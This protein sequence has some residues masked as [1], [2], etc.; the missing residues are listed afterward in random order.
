MTSYLDIARYFVQLAGEGED[1]D[2][3]TPLRLHKLLYYAQGWALAALGKPLFDGRFEAWV[4]G[5][6][7]RDLYAR[8]AGSGEPVRSDRLGEPGRL[9][10]SERKLVEA[11]WQRYGQFSAGKLR[12]MTHEEEPWQQAR[13]GLADEE[14]G[15]A[16]ITQEAMAVFFGSLADKESIIGLNPADAYA[17]LDELERGE[18]K[19]AGEVF[20]RLRERRCPTN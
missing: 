6:V 12:Q 1:G 4:N 7:L 16:E 10:A 20:A 9:P 17:A 11:V 13:A 19:P 3:L 15:A 8:F 2:P 14:N 18:G 5:P